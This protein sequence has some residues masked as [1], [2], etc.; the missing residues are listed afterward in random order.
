M[1]TIANGSLTKNQKLA[2]HIM[3]MFDG[4]K[5]SLSLTDNS[6]GTTCNG[7]PFHKG[8]VLTYDADGFDWD[9]Y[10]VS[11]SEHFTDDTSYVLDYV[12]TI[13]YDEIKRFNFRH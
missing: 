1:S 4:Y 2:A 12:I 5:M 9:D 7:K 8:L 13:V 10:S 6:K 11:Y 3:R